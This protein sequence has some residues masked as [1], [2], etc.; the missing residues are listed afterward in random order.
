MVAEIILELTHSE[1][2]A[3]IFTFKEFIGATETIASQETIIEG[4][5]DVGQETVTPRFRQQIDFQL[6]MHNEDTITLPEHTAIGKLRQLATEVKQ[7]TDDGVNWVAKWFYW[8]DPAF[9]T[10]TDGLGANKDVG[11]Y[12]G[13]I[14][15]FGW[16]AQADTAN[17]RVKCTFT[18]AND[19]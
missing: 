11:D 14:T 16:S 2:P 1:T 13:K 8:E 7:R 5:T 6:F 18:L 19:L 3:V 10:V 9:D 12:T 15:T 17:T 4:D